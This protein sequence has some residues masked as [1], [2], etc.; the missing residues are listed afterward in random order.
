MEPT[1]RRWLALIVAVLS[2]CF[3]GLGLAQATGGPSES[4]RTPAQSKRPPEQAAIDA[5]KDKHDGDRVYFVDAK[6][7]N[8]KYPCVVVDGVLAARSGIATAA[9][10]GTP[11]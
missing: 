3:S 9:R 7:K 1:F 8:R 2:F 11:R 4:E 5:C 10:K 6:G